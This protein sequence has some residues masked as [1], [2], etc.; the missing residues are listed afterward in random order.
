VRPTPEGATPRVSRLPDHESTHRISLSEVTPSVSTP[1]PAGTGMPRPVERSR[2]LTPA[3]LGALF[4]AAL[5]G[6]V[7]W[8]SWPRLPPVGPVAALTAG[9]AELSPGP[10]PERQPRAVPAAAPADPDP[11]AGEPAEPVAMAEPAG[12]GPEIQPLGEGDDAPAP[13]G[14]RGVTL[15]SAEGRTVVNVSLAGSSA[16]SQE[17]RYTDPAG[18]GVVLPKGRPRGGFGNLLLSRGDAGLLKVVARKRGGG[19]LVRVLYDGKA[20]Q[21]RLG[22]DGDSLRVTLSPR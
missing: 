2:G 11:V 3:V 6:V 4:G 21:G 12:E 17:V 13:D 1:P 18:I 16:G 9:A 10:S 19:S 8:L 7:A 20:L 5:A 14:G 22:V 15:E